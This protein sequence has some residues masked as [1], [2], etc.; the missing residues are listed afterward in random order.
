MFIFLLLDYLRVPRDRHI[1]WP[2]YINI[3]KRVIFKNFVKF[4]FA[5]HVFKISILKVS[6]ASVKYN[7]IFM[8]ILIWINKAG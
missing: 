2:I 1:M 7:T 6:Y 3:S 8:T 5:L 4:T